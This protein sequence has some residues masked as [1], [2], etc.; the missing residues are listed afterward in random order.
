MDDSY[1]YFRYVDN[2]VFLGNGLVYNRGEYLEGFSSPLWAVLLS[3]PALAR[4]AVV[5]A[6]AGARRR[7]LPGLW[8]AA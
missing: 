5:D 3:A 7:E 1:V 4:A 6:R 2:L 8:L